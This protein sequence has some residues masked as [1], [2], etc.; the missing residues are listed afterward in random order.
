MRA[1]ALS[2]NLHWVNL[3]QTSLMKFILLTKMCSHPKSVKASSRGRLGLW[4]SLLSFAS[5]QSISHSMVSKT[6]TKFLRSPTIFELASNLQYFTT[7][8]RARLRGA[9]QV[10][11]QSDSP[12]APLHGPDP[13]GEGPPSAPTL[14][15]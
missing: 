15:Q 10:S 7:E 2:A 1:C 4:K 11:L 9:E 13:V 5:L 3:L 14:F 12:A 8:A 6:L